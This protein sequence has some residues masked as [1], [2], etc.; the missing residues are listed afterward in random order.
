MIN[1]LK[2][3][4][5]DKSIRSI[6]NKIGI[7]ALPPYIKKK[8]ND[9]NIYQTVY[10]KVKGS[11][12][13]PTAGLHFTRKL[14]KDL[15]LKG[16]EL[17]YLT[18]HI[19]ASS[20]V[21]VE[22]NN[23]NKSPLDPE[24]YSIPDKTIKLYN[25]AVSKNSNIFIVGTTTMKALESACDENGLIIQPEGFSDLF[26]SPGYKFKSKVSRFITNFHTPKSPPLL[27]VSAF[28]GWNKLK[29]AYQVAIDRKYR[30]YSFGDAMLIY[31]P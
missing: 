8:F 25:K 28:Y 31:R 17:C 13:A 9:Y 22:Q 2:R 30:F 12:A 15:K 21:P 10:S 24:F 14:L 6:L 29:R 23:I 3:T 1:Y 4:I 20:F 11:I 19:S 27:M 26:I 7:I 16:V 5:K 18:L